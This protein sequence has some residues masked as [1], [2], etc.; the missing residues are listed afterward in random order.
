MVRWRMLAQVL[1]CSHVQIIRFYVVMVFVIIS[2]LER[3][4]NKPIL[5]SELENTTVSV[6][7]NFT[8][9]CKFV[10]DLHPY[11]TWTRLINDSYTHVLQVFLIC[12][13]KI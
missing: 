7:V 10:S 4:H 9:T 2:F 5:I 6:G 12:L 11:I 13:L 8:M 1:C 3:Y